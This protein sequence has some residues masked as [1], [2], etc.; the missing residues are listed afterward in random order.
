M[1]YAIVLDE[2]LLPGITQHI[3]VKDR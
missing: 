1:R 2:K 3:H